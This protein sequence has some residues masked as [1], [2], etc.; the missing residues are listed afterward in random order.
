TSFALCLIVAAFQCRSETESVFTP[1]TFASKQMNLAALFELV[2]AVLVTQ[3]DA[4]NRMLGTTPI[5]SQ[6]FGWALIP[7]VLLLGLWEA[8]KLVVRRGEAGPG[9]AEPAPAAP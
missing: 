6:Q 3:M 7:A 8:G 2:L 9:K 4:F 1:A 5:D